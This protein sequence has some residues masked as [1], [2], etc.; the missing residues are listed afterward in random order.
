MAFERIAKLFKR[1]VKPET[2]TSVPPDPF[3]D[4]PHPE[5]RS[6]FAYLKGNSKAEG[7]DTLGRTVGGW[8]VRTHPD[9]TEILYDL[10]DERVVKKSFMYGRP[11]MANPDGLIFA[12]AAGTNS[13]F[14]KLRESRF[15]AARQDGGRY[16]PTY[17]TDWI[18]FRLGGRIGGPP[19]WQKV[20][21]RWAKISY[22]D[23]S[24]TER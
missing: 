7:P 12:Y 15:D 2:P 5:N 24:T 10:T 13:I 8:E 20:L 16:D 3:L 23:L 14:F 21:R 17:R 6:L 9:L 4:F 18:E 1:A 11:T 22:D 19:D